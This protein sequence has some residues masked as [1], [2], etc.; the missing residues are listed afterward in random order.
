MGCITV[1]LEESFK[2]RMETFPWVNWSELGR[3]E[4]MKKE[5]FDRFIKTNKLSKEDQEFCDSNDWH[6]VDELEIKKEYLEKL[7]RLER[8]PHSSIT[9]EELDKLMGLK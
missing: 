8:G 2:K 7:K 4:A 5:I 6:P 3:E 1:P 9:L